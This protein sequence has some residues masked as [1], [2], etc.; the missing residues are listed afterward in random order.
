MM[1]QAVTTWFFMMWNLKVNLKW[2]VH[3]RFTPFLPFQ[4]QAPKETR[5]DG[6]I[7]TMSLALPKQAQ[8]ANAVAVLKFWADL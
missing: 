1:T 5:I 4:K 7:G 3:V 8:V 6:A 2:V